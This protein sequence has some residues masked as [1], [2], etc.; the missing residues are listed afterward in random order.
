M[1]R[2]RR[3]RNRKWILPV[4]ILALALIGF[5]LLRF[6]FVVRSVEVSGNAGAVSDE[7]VVRA[8]RIGFGSSIL[9]VDAAE[10]EERVNAT[11]S[12]KFEGLSIRYPDTVCI[13]VSPRSR[14]AMMLHMG[15]IRILDAEA[16]V[17]ESMDDVPN[18][19]L[20]YVSGIR[21]MSCSQ[22]E[23][24]QAEDGQV[25]A[26]CA[27]IQALNRHAA[28]IY[29]SELKLEDPLDMTIITRTGITVRLG[30][31]QKM[32]DKIA[33]MKSAVADLEQRGERGGV[34]DVSS[35][36]KADYSVPVPQTE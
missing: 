17:I 1:R 27:V 20:I 5:L 32:T 13:Q 35:G 2:R 7:G 21:T 8:A 9:D 30:D 15:K 26:Y 29:V 33:W 6:V 19:D 36:T 24:I 11:G 3:K 34:L 4:L 18:T 25:E 16:C 14:E 31:M 28:D 22:G 23:Q 12:L 10:I